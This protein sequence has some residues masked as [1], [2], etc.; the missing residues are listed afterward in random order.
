MNLKSSSIDR[1][2]SSAVLAF[3]GLVTVWSGRPSLVPAIHHWKESAGFAKCFIGSLHSLALNGLQA[4]PISLS[5]S[6]LGCPWHRGIGQNLAA[7]ECRRKHIFSQGSSISLAALPTVHA[8]SLRIDEILWSNLKA[9]P[10]ANRVCDEVYY[11]QELGPIMRG[12]YI[13]SST[14]NPQCPTTDSDMME[15]ETPSV[16]AGSSSS[17]PTRVDLFFDETVDPIYQAKAHVLNQA[18]QKIGMGKY[19]VSWRIN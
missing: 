16:T 11:G 5:D 2:A 18:I 10:L 17:N 9:I 7:S 19:Q 12:L 6:K 13:V 15:K 1:S 3:S 14:F 4:R 8:N